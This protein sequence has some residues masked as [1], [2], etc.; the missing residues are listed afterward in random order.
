MRI[1]VAGLIVSSSM[2]LSIPPHAKA[3]DRYAVC[4]NECLVRLWNEWCARPKTNDPEYGVGR[5]CTT[6][7]QDRLRSYTEICTAAC[8]QVCDLYDPCWDK[9][10]QINPQQ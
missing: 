6:I 5:P 10:P 8:K 1:L 9:L 3:Q 4:N 2:V 7:L